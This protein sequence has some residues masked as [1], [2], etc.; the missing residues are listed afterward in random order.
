MGAGILRR[1]MR[2]PMNFYDV[3]DA[4]GVSWKFAIETY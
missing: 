1:A 3:L 2:I 4:E